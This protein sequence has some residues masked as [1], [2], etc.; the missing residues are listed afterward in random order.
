MAGAYWLVAPHMSEQMRL[1]II[2]L[3]TILC[4]V[5]ALHFSSGVALYS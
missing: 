5:A 4:F 2:L 1:I 3:P